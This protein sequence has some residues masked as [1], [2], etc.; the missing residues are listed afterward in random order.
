M[1]WLLAIPE[2]FDLFT[3]HN[4]LVFIFD[5]LA[6]L[7]DLS[8][9]AV[10]KVL[11]WAVRMSQYNYICY[12]IKG[13]D[14]VWADLI[15]R[16]MPSTVLRR[17]VF[18]PPLVSSTYE[19]FEWPSITNIR[20]SQIKLK[21]KLDNAPL[22][23]DNIDL[24]HRM[25]DLKLI[26]G[27]L[28]DK[29]NLIWIPDDDDDLQLR[30]CIIG[31]TGPAGH[32]G[33]DT[34]RTNISSIFTWKTLQDDVKTFVN[35]CIHCLSTTKGIREPRPFG[36]A[37]HGTAPNDLIQ[38]DYIEMGPSTTGMKYILMM[39]DD[40]SSYSWFLP[41]GNANSENAADALLEWA[42]TFTIPN[43][44]MSDGGTHFRNETV[45][46]L[47]KSLP[48]PHHFTLP[49]T[50]WS[51]GGVERLGRE[52]L[53][54]FRAT[55][56]EL[57]KPFNEW[58]ALVPIL[59]SSLNNSPSQQRGNRCPITIFTGQQPTTPISVYK[60]PSTGTI[61]SLD[62]AVKERFRNFEGIKQLL[63]KIHPLVQNDIKHSRSK[64][65]KLQSRGKPAKFEE[66]DF[67]LVAKDD[68]YK[69]EKLALHWRGPRRILKAI[70]EWIY[71]VEDL[72]NSTTENIHASRLRLYSDS[73]LNNE[74]IMP[75]I[76]YSE[77]GMPIHRLINLKKQDN[78]IMVHVRWKGLP[79]SQDTLEPLNNVY[80]DVPQMLTRVLNR[81]S[82]NST[83][84]SEARKQLHL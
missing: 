48:V 73:K 62:E 38:F 67:V 59:Q 17:L 75:H 77:T 9:T 49:Y 23:P 72:R 70:S 46:M 16:W 64:S 3:D 18:V 15:S 12:H 29:H 39:R 58:P 80:E 27:V 79:T 47:T 43:G 76:L 42:T 52:I 22:S 1:H 65:R 84:V 55:L 36:P 60:T 50:P 56:S 69:G 10:K 53:R 4:N 68:S 71:C 35:S 40:F 2:G 24:K 8:Q 13:R 34:T 32:R 5:P 30:I 25:I 7:P 82:P 26:D 11:R 78:E 20:N 57:R 37:L 14:N 21:K 45:R 19:D 61:M 33:I 31:H 63:E 74:R 66:G 83:L 44:L 28:R 54:I 51:N 41:F 81:K 6:I